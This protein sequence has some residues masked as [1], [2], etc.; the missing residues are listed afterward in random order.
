MNIYMC[1]CGSITCLLLLRMLEEG[2]KGAAGSGGGGMTSGKEPP[3]DCLLQE[4]PWLAC[5]HVS[6]GW[7]QE[8][9]LKVGRWVG[10]YGKVT[11]GH[12]FPQ[13]M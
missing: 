10:V 12:R 13:A 1:G 8:V 2:V 6:W 3:V 9:S 4:S 5:T 7:E 11:S